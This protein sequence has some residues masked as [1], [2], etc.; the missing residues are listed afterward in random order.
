MSS[1]KRLAL[2]IVQFLAEQKQYGNMSPDAQ[3]SLEVA[4]QCLETAFELSPEDGAALS[5]SKSLLD[6]FQEAT[7]A[8]VAGLPEEASSEAKAQAEKFKNDG[9]NLMKS[10]NFSEALVC[11]SK[12]IELDGRNAVYYCNRAAAHS[13]LNQHQA[14]INDC[15]KAIVIDPSYSKAYGRMGLAHASLNQHAEAVQCYQRAVELEPENESYQSNLQI[16]EEKLRSSGGPAAGG[17]PS[18]PGIPDLGGMLNNPGLMSMAQQMLSNPSM[19]QLMNQMM[20]SAGMAAQGGGG[21]E[22]LLQVGQQLAQQMQA[23]NPELVEQ[24]RRQMG[25]GGGPGSS[26]PGSEPGSNAD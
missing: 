2:S 6:I 23:Q 17:I 15:K 22:S 8:E 24:L 14:A 10:E 1:V 13:K 26:D 18:I 11:Y 7:S 19:Q 9:N 16:A 25:G 5:V 3:E 12:A 4:V 21:I 20:G